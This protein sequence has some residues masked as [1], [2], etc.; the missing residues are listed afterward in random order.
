MALTALRGVKTKKKQPRATSRIKRGAKL[1][2]PS[3][4]GWEELTGEQFHRAKDAARAWYYENFKPQDLYPSV[5]VWMK[6]QDYS[7]EDIKNAKS[8]PAHT[9]SITAAIVAKM[10]LRGMPA[11]NEKHAQYWESLPG[12]MG[13]L[14]PTTQFLKKRIEAAIKEGSNVVE[15]K[16]EEEKEKKNVY[17]PSIQERITEQAKKAAEKIDAWLEDHYKTD[18]KFNPKGFDVKK[19][20]NEYKVTQAHAR[21][22]KDFYEAELAEYRDVLNIP[23]AGQLQK[24]DEK[25]SDLWEQLKEGYSNITKAEVKQ[26]IAALETI[27]DAC[28]F[29]IEQSKVNRKTRKPKPKSADKLVAKLKYKK[30][31]DKYNI[32]SVNP[33]DIIG[34]NEVWVFNCKTRKLGKYV[35]KNIDPLGAGREGSG[36]SVKGTTITQY[37]E[38]ESVQK[39]LRKPEDQLKEFKGAGKVKLRKFLEEIKTTDTKLNGRI[40]P[41]TILLRLN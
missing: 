21:K 22:I 41:D 35:A 25:E 28:D 16:M 40:N 5:W 30:Q 37:N 23:T 6:E 34:A 1:T 4:E 31:D 27:M 2:E 33:T 17:V 26:I 39:T 24:M 14:A 36:L 8:A 9:L 12:T 11:Y 38:D 10:L 3:W 29:V 15:E 13:E 18:V 19:H 20:F 7:K 32:V